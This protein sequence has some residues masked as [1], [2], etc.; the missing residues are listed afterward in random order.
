VHAQV[1]FYDFLIFP[2]LL[3]AGDAQLTTCRALL[4]TAGYGLEKELLPPPL[5]VSLKSWKS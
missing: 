3:L 4:P 5:L 2:T 1:S